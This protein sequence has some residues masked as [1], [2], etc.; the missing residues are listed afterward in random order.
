VVLQLESDDYSIH[1]PWC[2]HFVAL[3]IHAGASGPIERGTAACWCCQQWGP[4]CSSMGKHMIANSVMFPLP[5][6]GRYPCSCGTG[7]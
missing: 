6:P 3:V 7:L 5:W 4:L 2:H 1:K